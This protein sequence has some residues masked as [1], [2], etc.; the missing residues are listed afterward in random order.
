[1]NTPTLDALAA[2]GVRLESH[3]TYKYCAPTR[4]SFLTGRLPYHLAC[5]RCNFIPSSIPEGIDLGY[6]MLP[7]LLTAAGYVSHHVGKWHLGF[8]TPEYTPVGRGFNTSHGF[9]QG[10]EDHWTHWCG[11]S[12]AACNVTGKSSQE[13]GAFD[14]WEQSNSNFPGNP[15]LGMNGTINDTE[16]YSGYIFTEKVVEI[17]RSAGTGAAGPAG[18]SSLP[19]FIYWAIHNTHAPIES[20]LRFQT[21][22]SH[23]GD[24]LKETFSGMV[25]VVDESVKNVTDALKSTGAWSNTLFVWTTDNGSPVN[26]GGSNHPLRGG[27]GSNWEGGIRTPTFVCG[28]VVGPKN[29]GKELHGLV[30]VADWFAVFLEVATGRRDAY[31]ANSA[32]L[33]SVDNPDARA[34]NKTLPAPDA[35]NVWSYIN[36]DVD[37]SPRREIVHDHHMFTN[38]SAGIPGGSMQCAGQVPFA[39]PGVAALGALRQNQWKLI[40][41]PEEQATWY[42]IFTPN[43]TVPRPA[44]KDMKDVWR[45]CL[46]ACLYNVETDPSEHDDVSASNPDVVAKMLARF[47]ELEAEYHPRIISPPI[48][49]QAFC[50]AV[51]AHS[52]FAAPYCPYTSSSQYCA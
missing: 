39:V 37:A 16:T 7:K 6:T 11:A 42:G 36:G 19:F 50:A 28:G 41:G 45:Q 8:H 52:G 10:G 47:K 21:Q 31:L 26:A 34:G 4:G 44:R 20:P 46:P 5:T 27:K 15:L 40:V 22:Y 30:H 13:L 43:A 32:N 3:Y 2:E 1:V 18:T 25:S 29:R 38:A 49:Q 9:L 48:L 12:A 23:F 14:L 33:I 35:V 24:P 17:V 51:E